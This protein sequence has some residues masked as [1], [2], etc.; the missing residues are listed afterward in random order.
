MS[1]GRF[2]RR[3]FLRGAGGTLLTL[4]YLDYFAGRARAQTVAPKRLVIFQHPQGMVMDRWTPSGTGTGYTLS[5]ILQPLA[6]H[7]DN[8]LVLSGIDNLVRMQM[9]RGNA[10]NPAARS[11]LTCFPYAGSMNENGTVKAAGEQ[12]ENGPAFGPSIDHVVATR[13][14]T[15]TRFS[16][17]DYKVNGMGVGENQIFWGE[18]QVPITAESDPV[19]AFNA[20]MSEIGPVEVTEPSY[21][22]RLRMHRGSVLDSVLESFDRLSSRLGAEDRARLDAHATMI[23]SLEGNLD[24]P[25]S[26]SCTPHTQSLPSGYDFR[27]RSF[28][29]ASSTA[30]IDNMVLALSCDLTRVATLQYVDGHAPTFSWLDAN[31]PGSWENW[32]DMV[33]SGQSDDASRATMV[34]CMQ[35][36]TSQFA[37]LLDRMSTIVEADGNTLLDN[38]LVLWL[39]EFGN[40]GAHNTRAL[41]V[42][43]G[44]NLG[45]AIATGRHLSMTGRTTGDLCSTILNLFGHDDQAFGL[46]ESSNGATLNNGP[47]ELG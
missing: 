44:G 13:M 4:P 21:A 10:H 33:H 18:D 7:R 35:W 22:D 23:R 25:I 19:A 3:A 43:I 11:L 36:Y 20:L 2:S 15:R 45:G 32:H 6:D 38:S 42:V 26:A 41:P 30:L 1:R 27:N 17:L 9:Q 24:S 37:Y 14:E 28:D 39:S 12:V 46:T 40:G 8:I 31:V 47:F 29:D 16:R 5:E 34:Q